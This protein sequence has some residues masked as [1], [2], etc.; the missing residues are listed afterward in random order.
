MHLS[1]D[2]RELVACFHSR[3]VRFL[4]VGAHAMALHGRPRYTGD[5]DVWLDSTPENAARVVAALDDF[6]FKSLGLTEADLSTPNQVI[7]LGYPPN[8]ID[9]LTGLSGVT[10]APC[11][12][13]RATVTV[14]ATVL[15]VIGLDC[16]RANKRAVGRLQDLADLDVLDE[17]PI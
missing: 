6:G 11:Y 10:F 1:P 14:Q 2:F 3:E 8:R 5:V 17:D 16:L 12:E 13:Q 15:P 9:L 4:I 7:Q